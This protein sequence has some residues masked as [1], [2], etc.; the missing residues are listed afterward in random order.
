MRA[1]ARTFKSIL[2]RNSFLGMQGI[3][4]YG[5]EKLS[6]PQR[7]YWQTVLRS[8]DFNASSLQMLYILLQN[9]RGTDLCI[10]SLLIS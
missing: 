5:T 6:S 9:I 2:V 10:L 8:V 3:S 4:L 7:D 1:L